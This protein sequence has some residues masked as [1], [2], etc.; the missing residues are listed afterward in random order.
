L[1][2]ETGSLNK[3]TLTSNYSEYDLTY[4]GKNESKII[5]Q[6]STSYKFSIENKGGTKT[7]INI[8]VS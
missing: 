4:D 5:T 8:V 3:I 7:I 1:T 6:A 2:E